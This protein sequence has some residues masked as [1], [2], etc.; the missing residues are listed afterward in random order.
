MNY[1]NINQDVGKLMRKALYRGHYLNSKKN[2]PPKKTTSRTAKAISLGITLTI[3]ACTAGGLAA[4]KYHQVNIKPTNLVTSPEPQFISAK[5][6]G[7]ITTPQSGSTVNRHFKI[8]GEKYGPF[9]MA[10]IRRWRAVSKGHRIKERR[11]VTSVDLGYQ[12]IEPDHS[13]TRHES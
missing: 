2:N 7:W 10:F 12:T 8:I 6:A 13:S 3:M 9:D 5:P 4:W 11:G 1:D